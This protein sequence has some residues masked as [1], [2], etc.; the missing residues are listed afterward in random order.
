MTLMHI[1]DTKEWKIVI[2]K[3]Q[4]KNKQKKSQKVVITEYHL[5]ILSRFSLL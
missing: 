4:P 2:S 3:M 5:N 1:K